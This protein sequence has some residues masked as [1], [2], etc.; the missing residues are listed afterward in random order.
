M[1]HRELIVSEILETQI[2]LTGLCIEL[3]MKDGKPNDANEWK[4]C[5]KQLIAMR[6]PEQ[7]ARMEAAIEGAF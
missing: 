5:M 7:I 6:S 4:E 3:A 2:K 1:K